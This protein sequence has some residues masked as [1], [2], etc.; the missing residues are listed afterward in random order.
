MTSARDFKTVLAARVSDSQALRRAKDDETNAH[1][2]VLETLR[3]NNRSSTH[4]MLN[5]RGVETAL[6]RLGC[7]VVLEG[8]CVVFTLPD[9]LPEVECEDARFWVLFEMDHVMTNVA[10]DKPESVAA[11]RR[12]L[13]GLLGDALVATPNGVRAEVA[14]REWDVE[15]LVAIARTH[16]LRHASTGHD[17]FNRVVK[18]GT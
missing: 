3:A 1:N 11:R 5:A 15:P 14:V 6:T 12:R 9:K 8:D 16:G 10:K 13:T 4:T 7:A 18:F 17:G 2:L